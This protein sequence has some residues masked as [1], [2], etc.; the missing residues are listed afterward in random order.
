MRASV[1]WERGGGLIHCLNMSM[2]DIDPKDDIKNTKC[3]RVHLC[4]RNIRK[5]SMSYYV[6]TST[7]RYLNYN[8]IDSNDYP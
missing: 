5:H 2:P 6:F 7:L 3:F 4:Q 8:R 1:G